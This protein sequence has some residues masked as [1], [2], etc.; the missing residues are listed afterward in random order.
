MR[1]THI[2][3]MGAVLDFVLQLYLYINII[4]HIHIHILL[5]IYIYIYRVHIYINNTHKS[6]N[7]YLKYF[8]V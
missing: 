4:T 5:Y 1:H 8:I 3:S 2:I 6:I 7:I